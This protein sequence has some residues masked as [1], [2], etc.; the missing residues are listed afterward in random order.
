[1][2]L[3]VQPLVSER[4]EGEFD[5]FDVLFDTLE[6]NNSKLEEGDEIGRAHV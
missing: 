6:K 3:T 2:H 1:M 4:M 5:I